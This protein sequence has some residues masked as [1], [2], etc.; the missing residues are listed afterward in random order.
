LQNDEIVPK[1][2]VASKAV[3]GRSNAIENYGPQDDEDI[4][5]ALE[6]KKAAHKPQVVNP[7]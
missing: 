6:G 7:K 3:K 1:K 2:A 4:E 5:Q